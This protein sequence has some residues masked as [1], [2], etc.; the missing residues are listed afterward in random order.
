MLQELWDRPGTDPNSKAS[1]DKE[2]L[3][4]YVT[5]M[6]EAP[7]GKDRS[8][9]CDVRVRERVAGFPGLLKGNIL[10]RW[11]LEWAENQEPG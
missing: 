7:K 3:R 2:A 9:G 10:Q 6:M 8:V 11:V 1:T 5:S 4:L